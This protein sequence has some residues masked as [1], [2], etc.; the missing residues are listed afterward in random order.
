[1]FFFYV[2]FIYDKSYFI[3]RDKDRRER[4]PKSEE[5]DVIRI[6]Q[7]PPDGKKIYAHIIVDYINKILK[8]F[9]KYNQKIRLL[10]SNV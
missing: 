4:A 1:M 10:I 5:K 2:F 8:Q 3:Y 6:K 9:F 7:E